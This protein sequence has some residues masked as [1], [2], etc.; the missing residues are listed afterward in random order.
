MSISTLTTINIDEY[1]P[2]ITPTANAKLKFFNASP[3]AMSKATKTNKVVKE[4]IIVLAK[5]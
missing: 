1:D 4:V 3:P 5:T 2:T